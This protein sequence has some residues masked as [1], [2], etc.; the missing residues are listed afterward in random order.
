MQFQD[1]NWSGQVVTSHGRI[2]EVLLRGLSIISIQVQL[3]FVMVYSAIIQV[4]NTY[5]FTCTETSQQMK[6]AEFS[7]SPDIQD[8]QKVNV[9]TRAL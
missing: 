2:P 9:H 7:L 5:I 6:E 1:Q 8:T 4:C 3:D